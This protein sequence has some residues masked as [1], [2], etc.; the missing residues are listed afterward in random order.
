MTAPPMP[1]LSRYVLSQIA[2]PMLAT[3][4]VALL[5]LLAERLLRVV[6][7]VIGWRGSL[8]VVFEIMGYLV[9]HYMGFA[10]PVAFFIGVL[11]AVGRMSREGELDAMMAAGSG[12]PQLLRPLMAASLLIA[13]LN[14]ALL[15]YLQPYS[16]YAYR[17][18]VQVVTNASFLTLLRPGVFTSVDRTTVMVD[19]ISDDETDFRKVFLYT[20]D[21][22]G[23][24]VAITSTGGTLRSSGL[25]EPL[26]IEMAEG[27][28]Q[29]IPARRPDRDAPP[30]AVTLRFRHFET[31]VNDRR[32]QAVEP[33]GRTERELT[34]GE[35]VRATPEAVPGIDPPEIAAELHGRLVRTLS[36]P[37]LPLLG[38]PLA[39]GRRRTHRSYGLVVGLAIL[40][41][42]NQVVRLGESMVDDGTIGALLGLWLPFLA[43]AMLSTA[44]FWRAAY[45]VPSRAGATWLDRTLE[46][47]LA[48]L[49]GSVGRAAAGRQ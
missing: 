2:R 25:T 42:Y 29:L 23:D 47:L 32:M 45:R 17:A 9:P 14:I 28:H 18:A 7:L 27:V 39:L 3:L 13:A 1:V 33:R 8:L 5:V 37:L 20:R 49:P 41:L 22:G 30:D 44:L 10:L 38:L 6:D 36:I 4:L 46:R 16:R 26:R 35:L 34:L 43:F 19:A 12:L 31:M 21:E 11:M 40:I 48:W 24:E 15:G